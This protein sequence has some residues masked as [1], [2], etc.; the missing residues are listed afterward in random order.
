MN[1]VGEF[2]FRINWSPSNIDFCVKIIFSLLTPITIAIGIPSA[3][4]RSII[5]V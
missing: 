3:I 1:E 2:R 4:Q 5:Q